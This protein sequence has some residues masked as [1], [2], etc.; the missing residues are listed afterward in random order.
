[1]MNENDCQTGGIISVAVKHAAK[2]D[3]VAREI[4]R[5]GLLPLRALREEWHR[6]FPDRQMPA[7]L[8]R[9]LLV[10]TI[11]WKMQEEVFGRFPPALAKKL[12]KLSR[13][14]RKSGTLDVERQAIVKPGTT[15]LREWKGQ[16]Y[17]VIA[18]EDGFIFRDQRFASLTEIAC[19]ITGTRWSGP[20]FFGLRQRSDKPAAARSIDD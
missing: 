16:T 19:V 14:L 7:R 4:D 18:V 1:M 6:A 20:R 12:E 17:R 8:S 2:G 15:L 5:L 9:D 11:A 10:R 3:R 13:Q